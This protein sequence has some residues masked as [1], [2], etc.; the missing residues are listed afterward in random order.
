ME[1]VAVFSFDS[2]TR[3]NQCL[4]ETPAYW[5]TIASEVPAKKEHSYI[6]KSVLIWNDFSG[7][8]QDQYV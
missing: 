8:S 3:F 7:C 6:K 1:Q 5:L 2:F 4:G